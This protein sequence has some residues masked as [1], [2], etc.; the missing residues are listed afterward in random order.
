MSAAGTLTYTLAANANG[1]ATVTVRL[2]DSGGTA[3]GGLDTSPTQ[4]FSITVTAMNDVP[5]CSAV[6]LTTGRNTAGDATPSCTDA[7]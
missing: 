2:H 1:S 7:E 3:N 6:S 4:S 5:V